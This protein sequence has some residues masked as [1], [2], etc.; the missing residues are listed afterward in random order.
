[1]A[2]EMKA[3]AEFRLAN[4]SVASEGG[5]VDFGTNLCAILPKFPHKLP[6]NA[7][8]QNH[9]VPTSSITILACPVEIAATLL[10][11]DYNNPVISD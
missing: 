7:T 8:A 5:R 1:M 11:G 3:H 6:R 2:G 9:R 10:L 4:T